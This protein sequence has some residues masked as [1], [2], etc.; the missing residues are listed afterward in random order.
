MLHTIVIMV[1]L[2]VATSIPRAANPIIK[3]TK[4]IVTE[5]RWSLAS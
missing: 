2:L 1:W 5:Y 4:R 3:A